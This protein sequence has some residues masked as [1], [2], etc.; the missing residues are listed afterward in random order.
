MTKKKYVTASDIGR[1]AYCP[2]S[3]SFEKQ[4]HRVSADA[5][6]RRQRGNIAHQQYNQQVRANQDKRCFIATTV[7]GET[8]PVTQAFRDYRD[9]H[10]ITRAGQ[11]YVHVYYVISPYLCRLLERH[12][13]LIKLV[14]A[15]LLYIHKHWVR[16]K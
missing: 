14:K 11:C 2:R 6:L 8:H 1:M 10:L 4:G 15:I 5:Q 13:G 7:F 12:P 3:V 16:L 9:K